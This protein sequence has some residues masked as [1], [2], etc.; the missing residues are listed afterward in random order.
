MTPL[1]PNREFMEELDFVCSSVLNKNV[2]LSES[3]M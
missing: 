2:M 1:P 3:R